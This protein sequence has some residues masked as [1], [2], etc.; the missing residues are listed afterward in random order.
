MAVLLSPL[1]P[2]LCDVFL[3]IVLWLHSVDG[4]RCFYSYAFSSRL[5]FGES[6]VVDTLPCWSILPHLILL[7]ISNL[8]SRIQERERNKKWIYVSCDAVYCRDIYISSHLNFWNFWGSGVQAFYSS[9]A[10][11][12]S[13]LPSSK[14]F[15]P[16]CVVSIRIELATSGGDASGLCSG[17]AW[18]E[19]LTG[20]RMQLFRFLWEGIH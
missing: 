19:T 8:I 5:F 3:F 13:I 14:E 12:I 9:T 20:H 18:F 16:R 4:I 7:F 10:P 15:S 6:F 2:T 17:V 11:S 1:I